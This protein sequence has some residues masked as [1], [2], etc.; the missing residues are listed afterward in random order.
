[1]GQDGTHT[2]ARGLCADN[3]GLS[4]L[5]ELTYC[6]EFRPK[7]SRYKVGYVKTSSLSLSHFR[8]DSLV[9]YNYLIHFYQNLMII[10]LKNIISSWF[11]IGYFSLTNTFYGLSRHLKITKSS[12]CN[13]YMVPERAAGFYRQKWFIPKCN[14][15]ELQFRFPQFDDF[16]VRTL[17]FSAGD[18]FGY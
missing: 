7:H 18:A 10:S 2:H 13:I 8:V 14:T 4:L 9:K 1:M 17:L 12:N 5:E 11:Y 6:W 3:E 15:N 16:V